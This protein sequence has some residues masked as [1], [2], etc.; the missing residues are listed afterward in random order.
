MDASDFLPKRSDINR[1]VGVILERRETARQAANGRA[2]LDDVA[3][4]KAKWEQDRA[5]AAAVKEL[6][7]VTV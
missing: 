7:A 5:E 4:W 1:Q 2:H 3:A 6:E